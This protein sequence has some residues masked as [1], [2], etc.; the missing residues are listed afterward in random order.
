M[1]RISIN[2]DSGNLDVFGK[3]DTPVSVADG[4]TGATSFTDGGFILGSGTDPLTAT[5]RP[6]IGQIPIGETAGDP[7]LA[8]LIGGTEID[9]DN[10]VSGQITINSS[11]LAGNVV[12]P[13]GATNEAIA[14]YNG[15]TGE[16]IQD[17]V[18]TIT[19][20]GVC[21]G[22]TQLNVDNLRL[23]SLTLSSTSTNG[24]IVIQPDGTGV[25]NVNTRIFKV[26]ADQDNAETIMRVFNPSTTGGASRIRTTVGGAS[27]GDAFLAAEI[28][29]VRSYCWGIDNSDAD[30]LKINTNAGTTVTPSSGTNVW[31]MTSAGE[32]TMPLQP[33]FM[34][35]VSSTITDI[36]GDS[37]LYQIIFDTERFDQG[38]DYDETIGEFEAPVDGIYQLNTSVRANQPTGQTIDTLF[39]VTGNNTVQLADFNGANYKRTNGNWALSGGHI[40][41]M[42]MGDDAF[43]RLQ[44]QGASLD[45]D[46]LGGT[47]ATYFT[48]ALVC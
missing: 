21:N 16:L 45:V 27:S 2:P 1:P 41:D 5:P 9:I 30:V 14:R 3:V 23:D 12:G 7:N 25:V 22:C 17:S 31:N 24:N 29:G 35:R 15:A 44:V 20:A 10:S 47:N 46:I 42:D 13:A 28:S 36:T 48:G 34:A 38:G 39:L 26:E 32:S 37:A 18:V 4:G 6:T 8:Q 40:M 19:D 33:A 11:A 43:I